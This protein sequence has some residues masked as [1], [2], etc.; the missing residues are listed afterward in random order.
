MDINNRNRYVQ[1]VTRN[2]DSTR[3]R[4]SKKT[5]GGRMNVVLDDGCRTTMNVV[6]VHRHGEGD[7]ANERAIGRTLEG[8][9]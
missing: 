2:A 9:A 8:N 5:K 1:H 6:I 3:P 7:G 4:P